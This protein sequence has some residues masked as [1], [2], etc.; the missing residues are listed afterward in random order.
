MDPMNLI[1]ERNIRK[2][3]NDIEDINQLLEILDDVRAF[4][5]RKRVEKDLEK[6][7][8]HVKL[9]EYEVN[10]MISDYLYSSSYD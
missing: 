7:I 3:M 5:E 8:K 6:F 10:L 1:F 4:W 9:L 2:T